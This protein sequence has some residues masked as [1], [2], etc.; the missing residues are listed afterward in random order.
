MTAE[1]LKPVHE[2]KK[3]DNDDDD[4]DEQNAPAENYK[5]RIDTLK[6]NSNDSTRYRYQPA[7]EEQQKTEVKVAIEE[8]KVKKIMNINLHDLAS[9]FI[10]R[11]A[12]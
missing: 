10:E 8:P 2:E 4:N 3:N 9:T 1:G 12:I 6:N 5:D 7:K 11:T